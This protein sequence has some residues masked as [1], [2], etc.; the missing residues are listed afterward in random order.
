MSFVNFSPPWFLGFDILLELL[1]FI[2]TL[3]ISVFAFK[4][5]KKTYQKS[6]LLFATGFFLI[7]LSYLIQS[8]F[9]FF[10]LSKL[11]ENIC[12]VINIRSVL[13]FNFMGII[14][15]IIFMILGLSLLTYMT[16]KIEKKRSFL[17]ILL[18]P[19]L[20]LIFSKDLVNTFFMYSTL[21][22]SFLLY[23]F[24]KNYIK[25]K[26]NKSLLIASSFVLLFI[27][28]IYFILLPT[29]SLFYALGHIV[30][31]VAYILIICNFYLVLKR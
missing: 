12:V 13:F 1:F 23:H 25:K 3:I 26:D 31:L 30:N 5:Y 19:T 20:G 16:L 8:L 7:S 17:L 28:N 22:L 6:I 15:H 18:L 14:A 24:I 4:V 21:F 2:I 27:G 11:N 29:N 10:A 9:N